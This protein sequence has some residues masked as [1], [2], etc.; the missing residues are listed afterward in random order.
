[1]GISKKPLFKYIGL[2]ASVHLVIGGLLFFYALKQ[3]PAS[4]SFSSIQVSLVS[5]VETIPVLAKALRPLRTPPMF[6]SLLP[7]QPKPSKPVEDE[8][9][10][11]INAESVMSGPAHDE[12]RRSSAESS[13]LEGSE[14]R[15]Q[16]A[17]GMGSRSEELNR[18]L[19]DLRSRLEQAKRYPWLARIQGLEG[20]ARVQFMINASGEIQEIR[21]LESSRSKILDEEAVT[22]VKRLGRFSR[23]PV[24]WDENV[25]IQVPLV[26]QL[27]SP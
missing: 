3:L 27:K 8:A 16:E 1:M 21:L 23:L 26:F 24:S 17:A 25:Q 7:V 22:T 5:P 9:A 13:A 4:R 2:S 14:T 10:D 11:S 12:T 6:P 20:T 15:D 19:Q 18:F